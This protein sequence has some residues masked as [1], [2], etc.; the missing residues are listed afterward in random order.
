MKLTIPTK[1]LVAALASLKSI[2]KP[3]TTHPILSNAI[4]RADKTSLTMIAMDLE[5]QLSITLPCE[6]KETGETTLACIRLH[7]WLSSRKEQSCIL[8][9]DAKQQ[10]TITC[11]RSFKKMLGLPVEEFPPLLSCDEGEQI[12]LPAALF[13]GHVQKSLSH[14]SL[15]KSK[16]EFMTVLIDSYEGK[17][18]VCGSNGNRVV[19]CATDIPMTSKDKFIVP[20]ESAQTMSALATV[21]DITLTLNE[22][23]LSVKTDN[24]EFTTKLINGKLPPYHKVVTPKEKRTAP[25]TVNRLALLSEL[26]S[27]E[28]GCGEIKVADIVSNGTEL[29]VQARSGENDSAVGV[30]SC[31]GKAVSFQINPAFLK[32]ALKCMSSDEITIG[33]AD[34]VTP[35]VIEDGDIISVISPLR[36]K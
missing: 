22:S 23:T 26:E 29:T 9:S 32:D 31:E 20:R 36:F 2:A 19:I 4:L 24:T 21:G 34:D 27:A 7:D 12:T 13:S 17:L 33:C 3:N 35:I 30:I 1:L 14:A 25:I 18:E 15:D 5:K 16:S 6:V 28:S 10:A 8:Q 11:E